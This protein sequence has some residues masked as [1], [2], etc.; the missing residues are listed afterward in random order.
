MPKR[1]KTSRSTRA[2]A[3]L[4]ALIRAQRQKLAVGAKYYNAANELLDQL[5]AVW[6]PDRP[7]PIGNGQTAVL[8]D[9]FADT[10]KIFKPQAC[11][12][13]VLEVRDADGKLTRLR[14]AKKKKA[15]AAKKQVSGRARGRKLRGKVKSKTPDGQ[16]PA[17][18]QRKDTGRASAR[19]SPKART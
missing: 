13:Y 3:K 17:A 7:V 6:R 2:P 4:V 1:A 14:D 19:R 12:R 18:R 5:I 15:A 16:A 10:N 9:Q 11:V 8:V